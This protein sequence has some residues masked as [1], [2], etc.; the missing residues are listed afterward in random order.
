VDCDGDLH[1]DFGEFVYAVC[2]DHDMSTKK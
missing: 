1:L 2:G